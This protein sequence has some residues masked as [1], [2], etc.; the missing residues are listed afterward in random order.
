MRGS[1]LESFASGRSRRVSGPAGV[2]VAAAL[3]LGAC[4]NRAP[5]VVV[6]REAPASAPP[7][8]DVEVYRRAESDRAARLAR[9]VER[10]QADLLR[11]EEALVM[12]E[13][14]LRATHTRADAVSSLAEARIR[15]ERAA[16]A[17]PWR[18]TEIAEART[19]LA[20]AERQVE[21]DHFG[22]A[23]F[24][25]YRARRVADTLEGEAKQVYATEGT[26]FV[27]SDRVNLRAGPSTIDPVLAV[28]SQGTP[29]FPESSEQEWL[30]VRAST[31]SVGWVHTSL[32][33]NR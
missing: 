33:R 1:D 14:G 27:K 8:I 25:V 29:V 7:T 6:E 20:E 3:L 15:V 2:L 32:L 23:L 17:A 18:P 10:L 19:K 5:T 31:G 26:R 11:A 9:E 30:L 13:S 21:Q 16:A 4:A 24:F 12:A 28:L 22:A